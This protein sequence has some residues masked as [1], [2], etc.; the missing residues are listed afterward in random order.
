MQQQRLG[1]QG[2]GPGVR[3]AIPGAPKPKPDPALRTEHRS[4]GAS[5]PIGTGRGPGPH[6]VPP[7]ASACPAPAALPSP[8]PPAIFAS[9]S[10]TGT[11]CNVTRAW[12]EAPAPARAR[13]SPSRRQLFSDGTRVATSACVTEPRHVCGAR[14][15]PRTAGACA[16]GHLARPAPRA[17]A[18]GPRRPVRFELRGLGVPAEVASTASPAC[19]ADSARRHGLDVRSRCHKPVSS[20]LSP[21]PEHCRVSVCTRV[22]LCALS[23]HPLTRPR[24]GEGWT[25]DV[26]SLG[27][28]AAPF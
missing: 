6:C 12:R 15:S 11:T 25:P 17:P 9:R 24:P 3:A 2:R 19:L 13:L 20:F 18:S 22:C 7:S 27:H 23:A 16:V 10:S 5:R 21:M 1:F 26:D 28:T 4:A 14:S 8:G